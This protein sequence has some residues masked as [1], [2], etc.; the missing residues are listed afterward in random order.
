MTP[1]SPSLVEANAFKSHLQEDASV[2][3]IGI[4][5]TDVTA[6]S[7]A[8][9]RLSSPRSRPV[10]TICEVVGADTRVRFNTVNAGL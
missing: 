4:S 8:T 5:S 9:W 10:P 1:I 2:V 7:M 3:S 6:E